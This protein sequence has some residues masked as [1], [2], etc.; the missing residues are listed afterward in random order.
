MS[1]GETAPLVIHGWAV[2]AHPLFLAH[3]KRVYPGHGAPGASSERFARIA[4]P[5]CKMTA[6]D[7]LGTRDGSVI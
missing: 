4:S 3:G 2:F 1:P 5:G 6:L 7:M